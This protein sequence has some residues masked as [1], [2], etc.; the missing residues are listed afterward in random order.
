MTRIRFVT[1]TDTGVGKTV[2]SAVLAKRAQQD[3]ASVRY[4]KPVQTGIALGAPGGDA[5]FVAAA[6]I[7]ATELERYE[8]P[9]AP[10]VAAGL[11]GRPIDFD[12]LVARTLRCAEG[13]DLLLVEGAGGLLVPLTDDKTMADL[14]AAIGAELVVVA[15]PGLGTLN[16]TA[17]TLEAAERRGLDV[18]LLVVSGYPP[19]PGVTERTNLERLRKLGPQVEVVELIDGL[20]VDEGLPGPVSGRRVPGGSSRR[21]AGAGRPHR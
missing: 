11:A 3:G 14:A 16:H 1:G 21:R 20:S 8:H 17:L 2:V 6:G 9:L 5:S 15:R 18:A 4:V 7:E 10:A 12:D 13:T 19:H